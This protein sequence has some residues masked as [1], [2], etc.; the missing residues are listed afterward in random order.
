METVFRLKA[1]DIDNKL[2][3]AIR[4]LFKKDEEVE[5]TVSSTLNEDETEYLMKIPANRKRLL[6]AIKNVEE[7]KNLISFTAEEFEAYKK[8]LL[9]K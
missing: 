5:I 9:K 6:E 4:S 3:D 2:I 7:N 8:K 1:K